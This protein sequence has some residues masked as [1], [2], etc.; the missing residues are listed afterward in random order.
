MYAVI[1]AS[2]QAIIN[3]INQNEV[4]EYEWL[5][6][7]VGHLNAAYQQ[8]YRSFWGMRFPNSNFYTEYFDFLMAPRPPLLNDLCHALHDHNETLQFSFA[9]KL[10]HMRNPHL[11]IYD[12]K[13]ARFFLF[14][15]PPSDWQL[16]VRIDRYIQFYKFLQ[17]EYARVI[18]GGLLATAIAA[19]R[20]QFNLMQHT[21]EKI[22]DWI[23]WGLVTCADNDAV[24]NGHIAYQ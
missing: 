2:H 6:Q 24:L 15:P 18:N 8:L 10:L 4:T 23:I 21:D 11:P 20:Q 14:K 7:N 19:F 3:S 22:I 1:N 13:V 9:T 12:S 5:L 17:F 16:Q